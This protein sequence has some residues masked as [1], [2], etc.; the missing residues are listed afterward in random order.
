M[1]IR[2]K[3]LFI[4]FIIDIDNTSNTNKRTTLTPLPKGFLVNF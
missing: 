2:I 1:K 3:S 4:Y